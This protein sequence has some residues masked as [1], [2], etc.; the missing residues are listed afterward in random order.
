MPDRI[1]CILFTTRHSYMLG[2][3]KRLPENFQVAS[4]SFQ[5][6]NRLTLQ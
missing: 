1:R 6:A 4:L 5:Q 3:S 2:R